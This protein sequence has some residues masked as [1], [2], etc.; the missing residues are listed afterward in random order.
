LFVELLRP[1]AGHV[2]QLVSPF[3]RIDPKLEKLPRA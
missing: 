1:F 2:A 3:G